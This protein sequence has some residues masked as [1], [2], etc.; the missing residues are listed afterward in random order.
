MAQNTNP[1]GANDLSN[2]KLTDVI[3][4]KFLQRFQDDFATGVESVK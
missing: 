3:D 1:K 4:L 2:I